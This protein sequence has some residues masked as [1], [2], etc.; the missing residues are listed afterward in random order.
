[1]RILL[2]HNRYIRYGGEDATFESERDLLTK[3]GHHVECLVFD[4][5][6]LDR[7]VDKVKIGFGLLY[8][9]KSKNT[10]SKFIDRFNPD[11]IHV[12]NFFYRASPS[13]FF[14]SRKRNIPTFVTL[15]NYRLICAGGFLMR[16]SSICE[17]CVN[18]NF[19]LHGIRYRCHRNS[20][21]QSAH[22]VLATGLH[23]V[24]D[25][26]NYKAINFIAVTEFSRD[27]YLNSSLKLD[28][29]RIRVKPNSVEDLGEGDVN[30]RGE[31]YLFIGRLSKEKGIDVLLDA[32][33]SSPY[34]LDIIGDGPLQK[35]VQDAEQKHSNI[36]Y[37][38]FR[39]KDFIT[40]KLKKAKA[41]VF[42]SVWYEGLP[43]TILEAFSTGTPVIISDLGNLNEIVT[44]NYNGLVFEPN[45]AMDLKERMQDFAI[46]NLDYRLMYQ[47]AR[48]TYLLKYTPQVNYENLVKM[49]KDAIR[50]E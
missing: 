28:P 33:R 11:I 3:N 45:N 50:V 26:W 21:V 15:Q 17:L 20:Y 32:F 1:M 6:N 34:Q 7:L 30:K 24:L 13:I 35:A 14:V 43:I 19:P 39:K 49:Y 36:K 42:P 27:K 44:N 5:E 38:G 29:E 46:N 25:T 9:S 8:N 48:A 47:N 12:H 40:K 4:N 37:L 41:L 16:D 23:K 2:V 22:L 18:G 10:L 31:S